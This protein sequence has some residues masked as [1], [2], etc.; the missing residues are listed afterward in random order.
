MGRSQTTSEYRRKNDGYL[1]YASPLADVRA[2]PIDSVSMLNVRAEL[3]V[4]HG[5]HN[6]KDDAG[7]T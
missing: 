4:S 5:T 6:F 1:V 2:A 7:G 3:I